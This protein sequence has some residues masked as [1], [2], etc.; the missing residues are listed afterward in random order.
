ML[1]QPDNQELAKAKTGRIRRDP[2]AALQDLRIGGLLDHAE[3]QMFKA[4]WQG[5]Q[6]SG[7]HPG[8]SEEQEALFRLHV[9]TAIGRYLLHKLQ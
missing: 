1:K 7:P 6:D 9:A 4:F 3:E 5:I 8:L 2:T